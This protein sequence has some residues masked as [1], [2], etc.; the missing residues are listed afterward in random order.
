MIAQVAQARPDARIH[1]VIVS[2]MRSGGLELFVGS[3][4]DPLWGQV[5]AV[6]LGGIRVEALNDTRLLMLPTAA[7]EVE[8]ALHSL[9]GAR[10]LEGYRGQPPV[11]VPALSR[12]IVQIGEAILALGPELAAFEINPLLATGSGAEALDALAVWDG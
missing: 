10:L 2:P 11:D 4:R 3:A 9:S 8:R 12:T 6:G 5:L 7:D 1:G